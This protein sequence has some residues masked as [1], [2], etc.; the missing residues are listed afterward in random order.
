MK[1]RVRETSFETK[2]LHIWVSEIRTKLH[3]LVHIRDGAIL[4][5][6]RLGFRGWVNL[7]CFWILYLC[8]RKSS[9][10]MEKCETQYFSITTMFSFALVE[11]L[12]S[13][14]ILS[15]PEPWKRFMQNGVTVVM[16][17]RIQLCSISQTM[18][19]M[20]LFSFNEV[21]QKPLSSSFPHHH[22]VYYLEKAQNV[23]VQLVF[24]ECRD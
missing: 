22:H 8:R 12:E 23:K 6:S 7:L 20:I 15:I 5:K 17:E 21:D 11:D 13:Q 4:H 24:G 9:Q 18:T 19:Y 16:H 14:L 10:T 1:A 3:P 2:E